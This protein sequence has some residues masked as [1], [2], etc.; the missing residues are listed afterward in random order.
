M[1]TL[2]FVSNS[3]Y[4]SLCEKGVEGMIAGR[5]EGG[6]FSSVVSL[7]PLARSTR[8]KSIG[9]SHNLV[10]LGFDY[11]WGGSSS[12][13]LRYLYAPLYIIR[14]IFVARKL[15]R[16][17]HFDVVRS[18][19]P[20]VAGLV[21]FFA[22]R[23][24][25]AAY[26]VSVHAD[27]DRLENRDMLARIPFVNFLAKYIFSR[28]DAV[29]PISNYLANQVKRN[30]ICSSYM[31]VIQ[32]GVDT[33][34]FNG[35]AKSRTRE[36]LGLPLD[37][38]IVLYVNRL[39]N[40]KFCWDA[41]EIAS[42]LENDDAIVVICGDGPERKGMETYVM[43]DARL[44]HRVIFLGFQSQDNI[45][46]LAAE[47]A[48]GLVLLAGFGL[49]ELCAAGLPVVA[50]RMEWQGEIVAHEVTGLLVL[51]GDT[52]DAAAAVNRLLKNDKFA[53]HLGLQAKKIAQ[54]KYS[55]ESARLRRVGAYSLALSNARARRGG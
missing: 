21:G 46:A 50:Y 31:H 25:G 45:A 48:V 33:N 11:F 12:R 20:F 51:E 43:S 53:R 3:D 1:K 22:A 38:P 9:P 29:A 8:V 55:L 35:V 23:A 18:T 36:H 4:D 6:Y 13:L 10:E 40:Q 14:A 34:F 42:L 15:A 54:E 19:D 49:I 2:L 17:K 37:I 24:A 5:S 44:A 39:S 52:R 47:S 32:H 30:G 27:Y 16:S 26:C 41:L 7:H 28:A